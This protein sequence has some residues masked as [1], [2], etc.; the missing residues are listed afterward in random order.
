[1][2]R[3]STVIVPVFLILTVLCTLAYGLSDRSHSFTN[4]ANYDAM[5]LIY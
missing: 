5:L 1:M 3:L 2:K 4:E